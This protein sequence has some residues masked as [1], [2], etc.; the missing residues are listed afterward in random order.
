MLARVRRRWRSVVFQSPRRLDLRLLCTPE[1][2]VRDTVDIWPPLPLIIKDPYGSLGHL[3]GRSDVDNTVAALERRNDRVCQIKHER[4]TGSQLEYVTDSAINAALYYMGFPIR[5]WAEPHHVCVHLAC[6]T[7][8]I[9]GITENT[10][11][12]HSPR[13]S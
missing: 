2:P 7:F 3:N 4:L 8:S 12:C 5:S 1:T 10:F 9:S 6:L 13:L 11:V